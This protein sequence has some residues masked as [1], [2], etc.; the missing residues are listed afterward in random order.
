[1]NIANNLSSIAEN[2]GIASNFIK[3]YPFENECFKDTDLCC[4]I[5]GDGTL[6]GVL[7]EVLKSETIVLGI[8]L[9][10]LGFLA[11]YSMQEVVNNFSSILDG[12]YKVDSR[13]ILQC[14]SNINE[15]GFALNDLVIKE[16]ENRGLIRLKVK[17]E[18]Q[19]ISEYHCD[20]LIFATPT[21]STAYNL[22]AGGPIISPN[23]EAISMTPI[24]PHTLGNRT[25]IFDKNSPLEVFFET[26]SSNTII[27]LDGKK[28]FK[29]PKTLSI[30]IKLL[31]KRFH[32]I[33]NK[34]KS[35]FSIV[36]DKLNW[37][38]PTIR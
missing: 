14:E 23:V 6:L 33:A 22:S 26:P 4:V 30:R 15:E 24:C 36:K 11:T 20:G 2:K 27:T 7:N 19:L 17:S 29:S 16:I 8:N 37:G 31:E 32:L 38:D 10:K 28:F 13:S 5:G 18:D 25:V 12:D 9:G 34:K 3:D 21:G 1:M 35:H